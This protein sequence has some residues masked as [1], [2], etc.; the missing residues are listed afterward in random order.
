MNNAPQEALF[1]YAARYTYNP[2]LGTTINPEITES[3]EIQDGAKTFIFH[4][5]KGIKFH[6]G[7]GDV[8]ADDLKWNWERIKDP[9]TASSAAPDWAG[10]TITVRRSLTI[11][12]TFDHP[13]PAFINATLAYSSGMIICP[14]AFPATR[15]QVEYPPDWLGAICLGFLLRRGR[16]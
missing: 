1:N 2:P 13:Y 12:V 14:T 11:K 9:K 3:W 4:L 7:Y 16:A 10:S 6:G 5:R 15:R 8:T